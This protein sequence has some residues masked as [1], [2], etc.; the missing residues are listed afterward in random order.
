MHLERIL[1]VGD[2]SSIARALAYEVAL[3]AHVGG[4]LL[5]WH[6]ERL[7]GHARRL[8]E[9]TGDPYDRAW[10]ELGIANRAFC[11]GE[12]RAAVQACLTSE[13][14]LRNEC[15][16]VSWELT[17]VAAF[18]LTSLAMLG[19]LPRLRET[20]ERFALD[21]ESRGDLFGVAE[22]YG[23]ECI[24]GWWMMGSGDDALARASTAVAQ[25]GGDAERW[26]E[27]TYRRGQLTELMATVHLRLL[28]NDPWPAFQKML[29]HWQGLEDAMIPSLQFYRSWVRHGRA[30]AALAAAE[31]GSREAERQGWTRARLLADTT[32]TLRVMHSDRRPFGPPW[33]AL[34]EGAL[35]HA[36]GDRRHA[37]VCAAR[38][39]DGF[40]AAGM[41]LYREAAR[42][43]L[44][45]LTG[46][47]DRRDEAFDWMR[48]RG[49]PDPGALVEAL[50]P[51]FGAR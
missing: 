21:A 8:V 32:K 39:V 37:I 16:G 45:D 10:L 18:L 35:A 28:G 7:L 3:E 33:A 31:A 42:A 12:F 41:K 26:P 29:E 22:G 1:D 40:D 4:A 2:A 50:A 24:L 30:R 34:I 36:E 17:T 27:K 44:A 48:R 51:G 49:V 6:A 20:A 47:R 5:D 19:S 46:S 13:R 11:A 38:A 23:G 14:I 25:Q 15:R 9:R 43:R